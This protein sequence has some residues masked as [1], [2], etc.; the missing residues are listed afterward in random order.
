MSELGTKFLSKHFKTMVIVAHPDDESIGAGF[1]MQSHSSMHVSFCTDGGAPIAQPVWQRIGLRTRNDYV[2]MR[3]SEA[4]EALKRSRSVCQPE[5]HRKLD[6]SLYQ[7]LLET[8]NELR[9]SINSF[10]PDFLLTH[11]YEHGHPDHDCCSFLAAQLG[12][13]FAI[14]VWE[15]PI[16]GWREA[17]EYVQEFPADDSGAVRITPTSQQIEVKRLMF[18]A[19]AS[20]RRLGNLK[21]F[22]PDRPESFRPQ[23]AYAFLDTEE[24]KYK[25]A[26][27]SPGDVQAAFATFAG[28]C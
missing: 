4:L 12:A 25:V 9:H 18:D 6:G 11:S 19:H 15:M 5:F 3:E 1:L 14:D 10:R 17:I 26:T 27:A 20:Q 21:M 22:D 2:A 13:E 16:Y 28:R 8:A 7:A 23:P 24:I